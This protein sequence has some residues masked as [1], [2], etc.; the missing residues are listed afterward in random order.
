M[1]N[2]RSSPEGS[3]DTDQEGSREPS[4]APEARAPGEESGPNR[5]LDDPSLHVNREISWLAF[6]QRVLDEAGSG[7][8]PLLE[9]MKFL[10]IFSSNL[11][12]FF[13]IR[14]SG[15]HEQLEAAVVETSPDGL[16]PREEAW[17]PYVRSKAA[18][19][20]RV[21]EEMVKAVERRGARAPSARHRHDVRHDVR[22]ML[23]NRDKTRPS[24]A[25]LSAFREAIHV[26]PSLVP[27]RVH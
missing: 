2:R 7:R 5:V 3:T 4:G 24:R 14:V 20:Q 21:G 8:W 12:E 10:A 27:R 6:N 22:S 11:D 15:L 19:G 9:R 23:H 25:V 18:V 13:M 16:S 1:S 17:R 26:Q